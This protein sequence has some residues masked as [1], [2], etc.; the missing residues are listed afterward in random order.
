[1]VDSFEPFVQS[2]AEGVVFWMMLVADVF[3]YPSFVGAPIVAYCERV[4]HHN[5][6]QQHQ[7]SPSFTLD[8]RFDVLRRTTHLDASE[9]PQC[10]DDICEMQRQRLASVDHSDV[11]DKVDLYRLL[12]ASSAPFSKL[13]WAARA[14]TNDD[15]DGVLSE[16]EFGGVW[17]NQWREHHPDEGLIV[18]PANCVRG[19]GFQYFAASTVSSTTSTSRTSECKAVDAAVVSAMRQ[20]PDSRASHMKSIPHGAVVQL[21]FAG[22]S[23]TRTSSENVLVRLFSARWGDY[24][25]PWELK[26]LVVWGTTVVVDAVNVPGVKLLFPDGTFSATNAAAAHWLA[27]TYISKLLPVAEAIARAVG[28]PIFRVDF[29]VS[30]KDAGKWAINEFEAVSGMLYHG[31]RV[32]MCLAALCRQG[33]ESGQFSLVNRTVDEAKQVLLAVLNQLG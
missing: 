22:D 5:E 16:P 8:S 10:W 19:D 20:V 17:C 30:R 13:M 15:D 31:Q 23:P 29:F 14:G 27:A 28:S 33:Y 4:L 3:L 18:K 24:I 6:Q 2:C 26:F 32:Q 11:S 9:L 1:M 7:A 25:K 21:A 12:N